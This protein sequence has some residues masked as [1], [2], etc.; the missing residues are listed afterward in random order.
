MCWIHF[1]FGQLPFNFSFQSLRVGEFCF[2]FSRGGGI[3]SVDQCVPLLIW[4]SNI[5][6][7]STGHWLNWKPVLAFRPMPQWFLLLRG[8]IQILTIMGRWRKSNSILP[9]H[10]CFFCHALSAFHYFEFLIHICL[11]SQQIFVW[12][13]Q[14]RNIVPQLVLQC[15]F[16]QS[17]VRARISGL[18]QVHQTED[19]PRGSTH[20]GR[21]LTRESKKKPHT[22]L[23]LLFSYN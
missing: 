10:Q 9:V 2:S 18:H 5:G 17:C 11:T 8:T 12:N 16:H 20:L 4:K 14:R 6:Q 22:H 7:E 19:G 3:D 15:P 13:P 21:L 23:W 1:I